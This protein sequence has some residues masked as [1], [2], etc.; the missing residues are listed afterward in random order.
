MNGDGQRRSESL[1]GS[2]PVDLRLASQY[3]PF[4]P[5]YSNLPIGGMQQHQQQLGGAFYAINNSSQVESIPQQQQHFDYTP[6]PLSLQ[7]SNY[8]QPEVAQ[9]AISS[10]VIEQQ[11]SP[12]QDRDQSQSPLSPQP[13]PPKPIRRRK[14]APSKSKI[15][16]TELLLTTDPAKLKFLSKAEK[17]RIRLYFKQYRVHRPVSKADGEVTPSSDSCAASVEEDKEDKQTC[18]DLPLPQRQRHSP[19][20]D[21]PL[22]GI[23]RKLSTSSDQLTPNTPTSRKS[24]ATGAGSPSSSS[25]MQSMTSLLFQAHPQQFNPQSLMQQQQFLQITQSTTYSTNNLQQP[26][27]NAPS[28]AP[29]SIALHPALSSPMYHQLVL[30]QQLLQPPQR[31]P[32]STLLQ[33]RLIHEQRLRMNSTSNNPLSLESAKIGGG[34]LVEDYLW[35]GDLKNPLQWRND[36][37]NLITSESLSGNDQGMNMLDLLNRASQQQQG[38]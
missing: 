24:S 3:Q 22:D 21:E 27:Y 28:T 38:F 8:R 26:A 17:K 15:N 2:R 12:Y 4:Q 36:D 19:V 33:Q 34:G 32:S 35:T 20:K 25:Q 16:V 10:A 7:L 1:S 30:P 37:P 13:K 31:Q 6:L 23:M 18:Q 5:F 29:D 14:P 11:P 9:D